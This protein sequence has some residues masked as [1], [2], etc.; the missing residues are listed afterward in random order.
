[1]TGRTLVSGYEDGGGDGNTGTGTDGGDR[2]AAVSRPGA[3]ETLRVLRSRS[4]VRQYTDEPVDD[5]LVEEMVQAMLAAPTAANKQAWA[6]VVVRDRRLVRRVRAFSPG[7]IGL[8]PLVVVACF[9]RARAVQGL[10][11]GQDIGLL[12]VA[13]AVENLLL[14]A[15]ALGLGACPVGSFRR[16]PVGML[17]NL[18]PH[19]HPVLLVP[20]GHPARAFPP[21]DRRDPSEVIS[22]DG[23]TAAPGAAR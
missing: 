20:V 1:M 6:F 8:P 21:C 10:G 22:Y 3:P 16:E 14:A 11:N 5:A 19:L 18:P 15:H 13:M 17:L 4:A 7:M 23:W 12:C 2:G 9:D